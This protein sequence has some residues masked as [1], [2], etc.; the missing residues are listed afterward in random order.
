MKVFKKAKKTRGLQWQIFSRFFILLIV[1]LFIMGLSQYFSMR[2]YLCR[3]KGQGLQDKFHNID[4]KVLSQMEK[5]D[6]SNDVLEN[7]TNNL[8]DRATNAIVIDKSGDVVYKVEK[9]EEEPLASDES[10]LKIIKEKE[11]R[12]FTFGNPNLSTNEYKALLRESG[13]LE[14]DYRLMK[15]D[16]G[17]LLLVV[18]RKI[19]D[20]KQP[21]G[22]IQLCTPIN[23][24]GEILERQLSIYIGGAF[25][26][27]IL[28]GILGST[29]FKQ[30]LVPLHN[31]TNTVEQIDVKEL[32]TRIPED[33]GMREIDRL[34]HS[35]NNML[36]RIEISFEQEQYIKE[37]MRQFV[38]DASH[39]LRTPL[40]SI[41]GFVEIL[42][43]GAAKNEQQL[44]L[45]L[46]SILLESDRLTKLV[47]DLLMLS[48]LDQNIKVE[49][50]NEDLKI[51]VEEIYPQLQ[52]LSGDRSLNLNLAKDL[53]VSI[54]RNQIKQV[55]YNLTQNA[56]LHTDKQN[57]KISISS[58]IEKVNG[59]DFAV[60]KIADNGT[61][62]EK[63]H[64][65]KIYDRF[66]RSDTHRS[67]EQGGYGLGLSIVR[68]I[69]DSHNGK[70]EVES[71]V[72]VGSTFSVYLKLV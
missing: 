69:I 33:N 10:E 54:N 68:G 63:E 62:I 60:L 1:L 7:I 53:T 56:V 20:M 57:G 2:E 65:S 70:I 14:K 72:G 13:N 61:G 26:I 41:H 21:S 52:V 3:S 58:Y 17:T 46:N 39:E 59:E 49:M 28:G 8:V 55:I 40:T 12:K 24:V 44:N 23:D 71:E 67:R 42:L 25:C 37:K 34:S 31:M 5:V 4:F 36:E 15:T 29:I 48:K 19:G 30:T 45:A 22:L 6:K 66:F 27:L 64:L 16:D 32:H 47:N 51:V 43:R 9:K 11:K 35:F 50:N 18:W 38:S